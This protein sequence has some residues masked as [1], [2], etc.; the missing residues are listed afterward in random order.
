[1]FRGFTNELLTTESHF[2]ELPTYYKRA[3]KDTYIFIAGMVW[4]CVSAELRPLTGPSSV[5]QMTNEWIWSTG[6]MI[7]TGE[8]RRTCPDAALSTTDLTWTDTG[9]KPGLRGGKRKIPNLFIAGVCVPYHR[10]LHINSVWTEKSI[11]KESV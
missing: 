3:V 8:N 1:M 10:R 4:D 5:P 9:A 2:Q 7:L 6:W 11:L